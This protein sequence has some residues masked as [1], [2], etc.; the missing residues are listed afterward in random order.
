MP[1]QSDSNSGP[2]RMPQPRQSER[3]AVAQ[4]EITMRRRSSNPFQVV[5]RDLSPQGCKV[6]FVDR[7]D[8]DERVS[9]KFEGL[10]AIAGLVCWVTGTTAGVEFERPIYPAV[11]DM[12]VA[13]LQ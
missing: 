12:L 13:K 1:E 11:F 7:P 6:E 9:I 8:L 3:I 5:V 2:A 10:E 4:A